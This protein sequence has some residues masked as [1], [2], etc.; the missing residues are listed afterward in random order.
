MTVSI[1]HRS[2]IDTAIYLCVQTLHLLSP[3]SM[4]Y[5]GALSLNISLQSS[6]SL[7]APIA[8]TV[9]YLSM[10][11]EFL[12]LNVTFPDLQFPSSYC[13]ISVFFGVKFFEFP[14]LLSPF[15]TSLFLLN[16]LQSDVCFHHIKGISNVRVLITPMLNPVVS[17]H[18][19]N[20]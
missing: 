20:W 3:Y 11:V 17:W 16:S 7:P 19:H 2:L 9:S 15:L 6:L 8:P 13:P 5:A 18:L 4:G 14:Y 1:D 12:P 10:T